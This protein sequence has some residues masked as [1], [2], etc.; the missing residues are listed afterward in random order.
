MWQLFQMDNSC[1]HCRI[2]HHC[3]HLIF[4][5]AS[6]SIPDKALSTFHKIENILWECQRSYWMELPNSCFRG[7]MP[8]PEV[9]HQSSS[10]QRLLWLNPH[11]VQHI[12][13]NIVLLTWC[14]I[15][16]FACS[17]WMKRLTILWTLFASASKGNPF[18]CVLAIVDTS[19][20]SSAAFSSSSST[21]QMTCNNGAQLT[22]VMT[23][24]L[25]L[26]VFSNEGHSCF[27]IGINQYPSLTSI[28][29]L[30]R[31]FEWFKIDRMPNW[32]V[33]TTSTSRINCLKWPV[34]V[35]ILVSLCFM[36]ITVAIPR[37][38]LRR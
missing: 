25:V 8:E 23:F 9:H 17:R 21:S 11:T 7:A 14:L 29:S 20:E 37:D 28:F 16:T 36:T 13:L 15:H 10:L 35:I 31:L 38:S 19:K 30:L 2:P 34:W 3:K 22:P 5:C 12:T 26:N 32:I 24:E 33:V 27:G 1:K 6:W 18:N 4:L